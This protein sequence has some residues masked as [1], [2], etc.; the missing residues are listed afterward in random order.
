MSEVNGDHKRKREAIEEEEVEET[1]DADIE[2]EEDEEIFHYLRPWYEGRS[3]I[4][5]ISR[6]NFIHLEPLAEEIFQSLKN[7][8]VS[9]IVSG[10][11]ELFA[12]PMFIQACVETYM[13]DNHLLIELEPDGPHS[14]AEGEE[15]MEALKRD[16]VPKHFGRDSNHCYY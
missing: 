9:A 13:E 7:E 16:I 10:V 2:Q 15:R 3:F 4:K 14:N 8:Q 12:S 11:R 5:D 6:Q 1:L